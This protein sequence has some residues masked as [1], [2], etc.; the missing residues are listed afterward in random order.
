MDVKTPSKQEINKEIKRLA[1]HIELGASRRRAKLESTISRILIGRHSEPGGGLSHITRHSEQR[2]SK[3]QAKSESFQFYKSLARPSEA[4]TSQERRRSEKVQ[5][6]PE[7]RETGPR[8]SEPSL[9]LPLQQA[10]PSFLFLGF[11]FQFLH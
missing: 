11:L 2:L 7:S 9:P 1:R 6:S 8:H 4:T 5:E 10:G 3:R